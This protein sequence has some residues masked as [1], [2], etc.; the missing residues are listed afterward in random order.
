VIPFF[1][2]L[3]VPAVRKCHLSVASPL[4]RWSPYRDVDCLFALM[5]EFRGLVRLAEEAGWSADEIASSL[6]T[7]AQLNSGRHIENTGI[8]H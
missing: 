4:S 1:Q 5:P 2:P 6:L 8:S 7:L 3:G